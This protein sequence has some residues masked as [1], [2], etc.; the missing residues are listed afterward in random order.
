MRTTTIFGIATCAFILLPLCGCKETTSI[1]TRSPDAAGVA[2]GK[3]DATP[4]LATARDLQ[5]DMV[6]ST[7][8]ET[9]GDAPGLSDSSTTGPEA[10]VD[11]RL[12][13]D[14]A[15]DLPIGS[16]LS[17]A[18][19]SD[20]PRGP[21]LLANPDLPADRYALL[22][23]ADGGDT[24]SRAG[25]AFFSDR[26]LIFADASRP[27][28]GSD[29]SGPGPFRIAVAPN[30]MLDLV[31]MIDNSPSMAPKQAKLK[32]Q[33]PRLI[34]AIKDPV[35][36]SLPD[37]RVA[38]IDSDLGSGGAY[39]GGSCGANDNNG[40]SNWGDMGKF[41]MLDA[42]A[43]GVVDASA[44]WL[45][46]NA[47]R[48]NF[49]GDIGNVFSCLAGN[50]GT[51]G[52]GLEHSLQGFEF[53]LWGKGIGNET[54]QSMLRPAAFLGLVLLTDEDDCSAATNDG[55]FGD[56]AELRGESASLRCATRAHACGGRNL[57]DAPP[58]FP[59]TAAFFAPFSTCAARTDDCPNMLDGNTSSVF[60]TSQPTSCSPLRS[61]KSMANGLKSL[62]MSPEIQVLVAGIFGWPRSDTDLAT[63]TYRV[64][65]IPNPNTADTARPLIYDY[66]PVCY[67]PDHA[68]SRSDAG[69]AFDSDAW[70]W[71]AQGGLRISAF[72]DEFGEN[73]MKLS[74]CEPDYAAAMSKIGAALSK[75]MQNLC[76]PARIGENAKCSATY[77]FSD[78]S[79]NLV[80]DTTTM[81]GCDVTQS[82]RPCFTVSSDATL[83]AGSQYLVRVVPNGAATTPP[84]GSLL[85]FDCP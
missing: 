2:P 12:G 58:G 26:P 33:F 43:C 50:L 5:P 51:V 34:N 53:A 24:G 57:T 63:A 55:L 60:D 62:K 69:A 14:A 66:W 39:S 64:E 7:G 11:I 45:E 16:Q 20:S 37:L 76:V 70:G 4:D 74:I 72:I 27:E 36:G 52:C 77:L 67:D 31:F 44:L 18:G 41:R 23:Y 54:Q 81:R 68:P 61:I 84:A 40:G 42:E 49:T 32:A 8:P 65:Q 15:F 35:D 21:D 46:S 85:E 48:Q 13:P 71:G 29:S 80:R 73:G 75:K 6:S 25:D 17:D 38:I 59:T 78:A 1:T 79:G 82:N 28:V 47:S 19:Q 83:C 3:A 56:K 30:R 22:P 10:P 9:S